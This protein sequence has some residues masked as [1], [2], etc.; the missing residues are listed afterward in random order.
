MKIDTGGTPERKCKGGMLDSYLRY[1]SHQESPTD[2]HLWVAV[3]L[4]A[5][6]M[7]RKCYTSTGMWE[8][9]PNLYTIL[10]GESALTHKS[11]AIHMGTK[12]FKRTLTEV[13]LI[14]QKVTAEALIGAI[15][16]ISEEKGSA[17]VFMEASELSVLLGNQRLDD[18][19]LKLM[20][21]LWDC[22]DPFTYLTRSRGLE[23]ADKV[24]VN[25][26]GGTTEEWLRS[27]VPEA[28]LEGGFFSRL[29][30]VHR[31]PKGEKNP[32]VIMSTEQK[33]HLDN[34]LFD[35][36]HIHNNIRGEYE[37]SDE[38]S[39][40]FVDWYM[41]F[42]KPESAQS[43]MRGYYGRKGDFLL[44]IAMVLSASYSDDMIITLDAISSALRLLNDN[45]AHMDA[46]VK[47]LGTS[48]DGLKYMRVVHL[49]KSSTVEM[50]PKNL[51]GLSKKDLANKEYTPVIKRGITH[52][53]LVRKLGHKLRREDVMATV[54]SLMDTG[55]IILTR[56]AVRGGK[57]YLWVGKSD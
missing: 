9:Y 6:A 11:T 33:M 12:G 20:T 49:I 55:D 42:N 43:F 1:A 24:C 38:A 4:I 57:V 29:L 22:P 52:S 16:S 23:R 45:E 37:L 28:A 10:V 47:F 8:T 48:A 5:A 50:P 14:A 18:T 56:S 32:L 25:L 44:K 41:D 26:L 46:L 39:Q 36:N 53:D 13:P 27:S 7:G 40:F 31:K 34:F 17:E 19:F 21:D 30:L 15:S 2:F 3:T 35:L 54:D 51:A